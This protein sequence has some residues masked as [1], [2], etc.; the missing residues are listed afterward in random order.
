MSYDA[1]QLKVIRTI[2]RRAA[3][4]YANDPVKRR[5]YALGGLAIAKVESGFRN[6]N[7]GDADSVNYRQ[8]RASI[9]GGDMNLRRITDRMFDEMEQ[10][11]RGQSVGELAADIQRPR[12]DLRGR[13]GE[14]LN[15]VRGLAGKG[16]GGGGNTMSRGR[17]TPGRAPVL[18]EGSVTTDSK[19]AMLAA[20]LDKRKGMSLLDRYKGQVATG[21]YTTVTPSSVTPGKSPRFQ[22]G[23]R[24]LIG[25]DGK[26]AGKVKLAPSG[27]Y[28]GTTGIV[29]Q[30]ARISGLKTVS[31]KRDTVSTASGNVSDHYKGSK[32]ANARDLGGSPEQMNRAA[33]SIARKLGIKNYKPGSIYN[34][35]RNGIRYQ[36]IYGTSD[37]LDHVHIGAKRV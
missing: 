6:L 9:Y 2:N 26:P 33:H 24:V 16:G 8:E 12:A 19:G 27:S 1:G 11:D 37:H 22:S 4:R 3:K 30:L 18:N 31:G 15:S 36:L 14:E 25:P 35:T 7:H 23:D 20:L 17:L 28:G 10:H 34:V 32:N 5:R 13:Y 21:S 29:V